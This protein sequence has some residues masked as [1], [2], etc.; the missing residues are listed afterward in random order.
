VVSLLNATHAAGGLNVGLVLIVIVTVLMQLTR[1]G[2]LE[3]LLASLT[4]FCLV[5]AT[6]AEAVKMAHRDF[7]TLPAFL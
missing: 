7:P 6:V 4:Y 1:L 3:L 2:L 5:E